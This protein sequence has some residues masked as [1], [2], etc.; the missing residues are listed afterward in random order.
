[1]LANVCIGVMHTVAAYVHMYVAT[2]VR[3]C[4]CSTSL[5]YTKRIAYVQHVFLL[6]A[7]H[8]YF[9]CHYYVPAKQLQYCSIKLSTHQSIA[10]F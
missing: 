8:L 7:Y 1:M 9:N 6:Y 4:G 2:Y 3:S 5:S 10:I